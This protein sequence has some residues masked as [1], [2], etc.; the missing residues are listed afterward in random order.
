[1]TGSNSNH[2]VV[3]YWASQ[4]QYSMQDLLKFVVEAERGG[5]KTCLT[6]DHFHPW[7]HDN[8]YGNF[9][10]I[11]MAAAAE[12][13][14]NMQF[15]TGVTA[16]VYRYNPAIIAQAFAS[17]DVLYPGRIGIGVGTGE[18]MNEVPLGFDWPSADIR[19][20]RTTESIQ[21][22]N[23]LWK[24]GRRSTRSKGEDDDYNVNT[25]SDNDGFI[26]FNGDYFKIK[27][28]KL[29]TP[30]SSGKIPLYMAA[31]GEKATKAAAKHTDGL[32][33]VTKPDKS[34]EI[35]EIFDKAAN[36]EAKDPKSLEK[37]AK[38]KISYSED[39]DKALKSTEFWRASLLEDVFNLD[40]SDPRELE[41]KAKSEVSDEKLRQS[42][43]IITSIEDCIKPLEEYFKAGY[44]RLY[45]H[46]TSPDEIKFIQ[47]FCAKVLP[48]F[49][50]RNSASR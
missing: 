12:R 39:Y 5:L 35:F 47:D 45:P 41:Q 7:W 27:N 16:A 43:L 31:V 20:A 6:S 13:T 42:T 1:M 44:T 15:I 36:E 4:E 29:Y 46:S 18:A 24:E 26:D 21:I 33:T 3:G 50:N 40:I 14:K 37:I 17:L 9:T 48:Y 32:I 8:G 10:W 28:A 19:L 30:P 34:K 22:I 2:N 23:K 49:N 38:P 25:N 11:W